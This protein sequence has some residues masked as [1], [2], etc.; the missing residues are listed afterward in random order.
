LIIETLIAEHP[1]YA[2]ELRRML[3]TVTALAELGYTHTAC[4]VGNECLRLADSALSSQSAIRNLQSQVTRGILG[5]FQILR[6]IGRGG[7]GVVYEAEQISLRRRVALK[8]LPF[9][10]LLDGNAKARFENEARDRLPE[11]HNLPSV[12]LPQDHENIRGP[13]TFH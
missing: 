9:A 12:D 10:A 8:V 13:N 3:P 5:D 2:E 1:Q 7:M 4:G 6:E 11:P